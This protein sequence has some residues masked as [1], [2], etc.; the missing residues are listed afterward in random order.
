MTH[1]SEIIGIGNGGELGV[2]YGVS[3]NLSATQCAELFR[4]DKSFRKGKLCYRD[5]N[6]KLIGC[7]ARI[8]IKKRNKK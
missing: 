2:E 5:N 4:E 7:Y 6:G 8:L 3:A 1:R